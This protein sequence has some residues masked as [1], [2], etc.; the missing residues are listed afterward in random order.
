[1]LENLVGQLPKECR[2][3]LDM[4]SRGVAISW[5]W[6]SIKAREARGSGSSFIAAL[7]RPG[8]LSHATVDC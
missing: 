3:T 6:V 8:N 2:R 1:M 4:C 5:P 7:N